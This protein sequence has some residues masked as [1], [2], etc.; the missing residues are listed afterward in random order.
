M[1]FDPIYTENLEEI[2]LAYGLPKDIFAVIIMFC[3]NMKTTVHSPNGDIDFF[4]TVAGVLQGN[5]FVLY[6]F[7]ICLYYAL[8]KSTDLKEIALRPAPPPQKKKKTTRSR[9]YPAETITDTDSA[10]DIALINTPTKA[11]CLLS[12]LDE[13]TWGFDFHVN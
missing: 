2:L 6:L 10:E 11:E 9:R 4:N 13:A 1:L 8:W 3:R 7:I 5:T 12:F